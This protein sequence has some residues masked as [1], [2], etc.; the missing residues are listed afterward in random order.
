M[1]ESILVTIR[2]YLVGSSEDAGFDEELLAAINTAIFK[3]KQVGCW[4]TSLEVIDDTAT[5]SDLIGESDLDLSSVKS[6]IKASVR[7]EF[8]PPTTGHHTELLKQQIQELEYRLNLETIPEIIE[9]VLPE[10]DI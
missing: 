2:L 10:E 3:L 4:G 7:M 9:P 5:W 6:Y 1:E 8:D